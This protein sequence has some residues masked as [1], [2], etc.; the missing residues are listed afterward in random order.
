MK[1]QRYLPLRVAE[2]VPWLVN[3]YLKLA[4]HGTDLGVPSAR[5]ASITADCRWLVYV[6]GTWLPAVRAWQKSCTNAAEQAQSG[7]GV[8]LMALP[9]FNA[10][11]LPAAIPASGLPAVV[12]VVDGALERIFDCIGEIKR[13]AA[14][15]V[16]VQKDMG[17]IGAQQIGPDFA[18]ITPELKLKISGNQ[19]FVGWDWRGFAKFL[20]QCEIQVNRGTGW[21]PLTF[22]TTP[23]YTDTEAFPAA[24]T[25]WKYRAIFRVDDAQV[26][27]WSAEARI[28]VGG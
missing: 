13:L 28:A 15:T 10:P 26:G 16:A 25:E 23:G 19:V 22:D 20:D 7:P 8:A 12:P 11:A 2:Q 1:R 5:L 21:Q 9:V 6:L 4:V 18:T 3:F 27:V 24:L 14:C 17:I